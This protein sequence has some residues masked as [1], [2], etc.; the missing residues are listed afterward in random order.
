VDEPLSHAPHARL[1]AA[2]RSRRGFVLLSVLLLAVLIV[3]LTMGHARHALMAADNTQATLRAQG[4]E[5]AADSG[6]A[7]A[8]QSLLADGSRS[9]SLSLGSEDV[10]ISVVDSGATLRSVTVTASGE[11]YTQQVSGVLETY[12]T[13]GSGMPSLTTAAR[14][15]V[16]SDGARIDVSGTVT[17][18]DTTL[19][20]TLYLRNGASVTLRNVVLQGSIVSEPACSGVAWTLAQRTSI[21]IDGGLL[22]EPTATLPGCAI[23]A[24]DAAITGTGNDRVQLHGVVLARSLTLPGRGALHA[25]VV[26]TEPIALSAS[27]DQPGSGRAPRAWPDALDTGAE[28]VSRASFPEAE[29]TETELQNIGDYVFPGGH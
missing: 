5:H 6:F 20:G 10:T 15:A 4:A 19:T 28:G 8:K 1:S 29:V 14:N 22:I 9:T 2:A 25:Q 23:V 13:T 21:T 12:K 11:G 18:S 24:P 7:W 26:T 16:Q 3:S 27:I 17:Y